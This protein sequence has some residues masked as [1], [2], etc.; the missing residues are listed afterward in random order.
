V[1]GVGRRDRGRHCPPLALAAGTTSRGLGIA[2]VCLQQPQDAYGGMACII[3]ESSLE[4]ILS[5]GI[6][7][8]CSTA[9]V[10]CDA[11]RPAAVVKETSCDSVSGMFNVGL[12]CE[13]SLNMAAIDS[14]TSAVAHDLCLATQACTD[15]LMREGSG[16]SLM[17]EGSGRSLMREGSAL[18]RE[19]SGLN[20]GAWYRYKTR[21]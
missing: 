7:R 1:A 18:L 14:K 19:G 9:M 15:S 8:E 16:R 2:C 13:A 17:R 10:A 5:S 4:T 12:S 11:K 21:P 6:A 3:R 20:M